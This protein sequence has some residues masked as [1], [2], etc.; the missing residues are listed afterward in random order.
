MMVKWRDDTAD[1]G[2]QVE[3]IPCT[4]I[5]ASF[6]FSTLSLSL[7]PHHIPT[8]RSINPEPKPTLTDSLS[9][10]SVQNFR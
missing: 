4:R 5:N 7:S 3:C 10:S 9:L 6:L 8:L 2:I 1:L